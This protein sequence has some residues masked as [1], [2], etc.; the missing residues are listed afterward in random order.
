MP[1]NNLRVV[2][3][4]AGV[5]GFRLGFERFSK[6]FE[7][8]WA[9]QWEPGDKV[10]HAY[11]C[12]TT[13]F[14]ESI[15][16]VN[17]DIAI[18]KHEVPE[19]D[20][21][22]GGFPCQD[23]SVA[24][25]GAQGIEGKKGVLW[26]HIRD[27][28]TAHRPSYVLLENVDRLIK[29]PTSQ[30][31]RD[32]GVILRCL[33]DLEYDVE[34]RVINAAD[35][36]Q[37]QRRR[38]VFIFAYRNDTCLSKALHDTFIQHHDTRNVLDWLDNEGFFARTFAVEK[39]M[40]NIGFADYADISSASFP[41]LVDLSNSF[42]ADFMN[43]GIM[44]KY[45]IFTANVK[46]KQIPSVTLGSIRETGFIDEHFFLE[47]SL[48]KWEFLKGAKKIP[49]VKPNGEPYFYT[50]GGMSFP[51]DLDKPSRTMLTSESSLNRSTHVIED[52]KT[53]KLR[54][55]TPIECERLN[56][57]PDGWTD[58]GMPLKKRYF[59]MGNALVVPL[60]TMMAKTILMIDKLNENEQ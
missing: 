44:T 26:W 46:P 17:M 25:T 16:H 38:R 13:R 7:T 39:I 12:Y 5:G 35:Y 50:E 54:L 15:S 60:I 29:S 22:C 49:R 33:A 28:I 30:R 4:F 34:W 11:N 18:A 43:S 24:R 19:H 8:I 55:L 58:T 56:G 51:D 21:L 10:Q 59:M 57:F 14:G 47:G 23:Y 36:G 53:G 31:G 6:Q 48:D 9:N 40:G 45:K 41:D 1:T 2:E 27:I 3:L 52:E 32:F 42:S 37:A 20:L